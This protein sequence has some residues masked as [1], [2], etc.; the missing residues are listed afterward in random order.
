MKALQGG[1]DE[2]E[3][4]SKVIGVLNI[5]SKRE[6]APGFYRNCMVD[7]RSLQDR[8]EQ[9]LREISEY[10]SYVMS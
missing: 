4:S 8:Q 10:C 5:D 7:G 9:A 2:P 3:L 1:K 6:D